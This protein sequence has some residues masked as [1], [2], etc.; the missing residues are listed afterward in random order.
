MQNG[1]ENLTQ[2]EHRIIRAM[3]DGY[4]TNAQIAAF[5]IISP[6][7]VKNHLQN[8]FAKTGAT[9]RLELCLRYLTK[10]SLFGS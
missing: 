1:Y 2:S 4:W 9:N 7:T 10:D 6:R 3:L 8:I 5:L